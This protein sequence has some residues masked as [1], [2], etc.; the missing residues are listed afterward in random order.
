MRH[1][2]ENEGSGVYVGAVEGWPETGDIVQAVVQAGFAR[3]RLVPLMLVAG[4][5]FQ[6]DL[7]GEEGSW[8]DLFQEQGV[9]VSIEERSLGHM[10]GIIDLFWRHIRDALAVI[11]DSGRSRVEV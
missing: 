4:I 8:K 11:P 6:E 3:V 9:E 2:K 1:I 7:A 5:H 10:P